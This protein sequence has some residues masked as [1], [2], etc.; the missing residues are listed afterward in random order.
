MFS[1]STAWF[2]ALIAGF[3]WPLVRILAVFA[4]EPFFSSR[5]IPRL[6]KLFLGIAITLM[7]MPILPPMPK[8]E[9]FSAI[10]IFIT[11]NQILIGLAIGFSMRIAFSAME[12]AGH[13]SGLQMGLGFASFFDPQHNQQL[14]I[15]A[16]F[17]SLLAVLLYLAFDA[18]LAMISTLVQSFYSLPITE[19]PLAAKGFGELFRMGGL[20]FGYGLWLAMPVIAVLLVANLGIGVMARAAPQ[21]NLFAVGF[22]IT[23]ALGMAAFYIT[24][25]QMS[26]QFA[27][28]VNEMLSYAGKVLNL[29]LIANKH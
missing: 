11:L 8:V 27:G 19:H 9:P 24:L 26:Q 3:W 15:L 10:G 25:P 12:M 1:V 6:T 21:M 4:A 14:P 16:L 29:L 5:S 17:T 13:L 23:L 28:L 7:I 18:H 20:V 22:P 2:D